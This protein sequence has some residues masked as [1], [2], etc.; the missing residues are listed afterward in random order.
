MP[1]LVNRHRNMTLNVKNGDLRIVVPNGQHFPVRSPHKRRWQTGLWRR[2]GGPKLLGNYNAF[3]ECRKN[4]K[5]ILFIFFRIQAR[6][7]THL[8]PYSYPLPIISVEW[9]LLTG[10]PLKR[11]NV[12][13]WRPNKFQML[14]MLSSW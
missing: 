4:L 9:H 6:T 11:K 10:L 7:Q 3:T 13:L 1:N 5:C 2:A 14:Q 12:H 8:R